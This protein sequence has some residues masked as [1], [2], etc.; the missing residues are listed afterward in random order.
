M[1]L[2]RDLALEP[3]D[4]VDDFISQ[5][6]PKPGA[7]DADGQA[8]TEEDGGYAGAGGAD[9]FDDPDVARLFDHDHVEDYEDQKYGD[10]ADNREQNHQQ[11]LF[12][13]DGF[14]DVSLLLVPC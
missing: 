11:H 8:I 4:V 7:N 9:A 14:E 6:Q 1:K 5:Q 2:L 12:M 10:D 13:L 3:I